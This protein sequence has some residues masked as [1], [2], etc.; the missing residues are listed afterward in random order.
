ME[1]S[2]QELGAR[3]RQYMEFKRIGT[4]QL[5]RM[6]GSSGALVSNILKGKNFG[7]SK[8]LAIGRT[9]T[10]L[11]LFWLLT[12]NGEML[13]DF[14]NEKKEVATPNEG[15]LRNKDLKNE[16]LRNELELKI[17][18]LES[19]ITYQDMTIE[20]YKKTLSTVTASNKDLKEMLNY[21]IKTI[22]NLTAGKKTA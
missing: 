19:A 16:Y 10:D 6:I 2:L 20:A 18:F 9:C 1:R 4:N 8:F 7:I 11:H 3:L 14:N 5:G 22:N 21:H 15:H 12:G 13:L 17:N